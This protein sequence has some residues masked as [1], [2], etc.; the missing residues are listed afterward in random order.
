MDY[1]DKL[2]HFASQD[3]PPVLPKERERSQLQKD[4]EAFLAKGG[5]ITQAVSEN[6]WPQRRSREQQINFLKT[7][8]F[9]RR[10]SA[11]NNKRD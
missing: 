1:S 6:H 5:E 4:I 10:K 7:K 2:R 3:P 8:D 9:E 11:K